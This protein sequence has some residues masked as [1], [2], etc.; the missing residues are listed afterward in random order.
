MR[1]SSSFLG[2]TRFPPLALREIKDFFWG[3]DGMK[4]Q[5]LLM[6]SGMAM[7]RR[8]D[9]NSGIPGHGAVALL[10]LVICAVSRCTDAQ[11]QSAPSPGAR[12]RLSVSFPRT[13]N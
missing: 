8:R 2:G 7:R 11:E 6:L 12:P 1:C 13:Y 10:L 9:G 4:A 3:V 5:F